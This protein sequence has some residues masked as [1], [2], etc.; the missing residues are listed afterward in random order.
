M[1][2]EALN[3]NARARRKPHRLRPKYDEVIAALRKSGC[4]LGP[5]AQ[6]LGVSR[7]NLQ[8]QIR[9]NS[10][11]SAAFK[12]LN[13]SAID[14]VEGSLWHR[15]I[16][17]RDVAAAR[18]IL[19]ARGRARGYGWQPGDAPGTGDTTQLVIQHV[20]INGIESGKHFAAG[21]EG[22]L[23]IEGSVDGEVHDD[24]HTRKIS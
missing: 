2:A 7:S 24:T 5:A 23:T 17:D 20:T 11:L 14:A 1:Q 9:N 16:H 18:I 6:L 21:D 3:P 19:N 8:K 15:A 4:F 22:M 13:E 10:R 12:D